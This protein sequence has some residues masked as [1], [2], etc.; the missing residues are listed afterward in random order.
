MSSLGFSLT[1][2]E[3]LLYGVVFDLLALAFAFAFPF[4]EAFAFAEAL[5]FGEAF[6][7]ALPA[8]FF[9]T[10]SSLSAPASILLPRRC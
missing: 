5:P 10:S 4:G 9:M 7:L 8:G 1:L 2:E 6:A 3:G